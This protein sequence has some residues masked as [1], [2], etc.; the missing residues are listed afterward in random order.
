MAEQKKV[1]EAG[2]KLSP[3]QIVIRPLL[4]EKGIHRASRSNQYSFEVHTA[5]TKDDIRE[6]VEDLFNVK[7]VRVATQNRLGK[8]RRFKYR[9]G[10]S[11]VWK[12]AIVTLSDEHR[13]DFF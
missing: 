4:T 3:H 13:L 10:Q 6:A 5:A 8:W 12:K 2:L 1:K 11:K 7:V 9:Q